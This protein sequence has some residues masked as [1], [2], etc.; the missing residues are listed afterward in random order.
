MIT[1]RILTWAC[2][3]LAVALVLSLWRSHSLSEDR[4]RYRDALSVERAQHAVTRRSL[5]VLEQ[6][7]SAMVLD[8]ALREDRLTQALAAQAG[9]TAAL[10]READLIRDIGGNIQCR[11]PVEIMRSGGL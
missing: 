11:T 8:G 10:Q 1:S 4:D 9:E 5:D 3:A 7:L 2:A 6:E